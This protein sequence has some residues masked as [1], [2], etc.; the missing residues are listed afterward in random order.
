MQFGWAQNLVVEVRGLDEVLQHFADQSKASVAKPHCPGS[1]QNTT[2]S[3]VL[4]CEV[5]ALHNTPKTIHQ[6]TS[7]TLIDCDSSTAVMQ[8]WKVAAALS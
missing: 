7:R 6:L 4:L 1:L 2:A 8:A 3:Y 5:G